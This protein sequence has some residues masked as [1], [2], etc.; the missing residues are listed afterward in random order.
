MHGAYRSI[1]AF[2]VSPS[3]EDKTNQVTR[4]ESHGFVSLSVP[5]GVWEIKRRVL[6]LWRRLSAFLIDLGPGY[7]MLLLTLSRTLH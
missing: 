2:A 7:S 4:A 6:P 1:F 5:S 3:A